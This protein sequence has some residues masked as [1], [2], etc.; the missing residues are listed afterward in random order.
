MRGHNTRLPIGH[1]MYAVGVMPLI[2]KLRPKEQPEVDVAF[3][4]DEEGAVDVSLNLSEPE[5]PCQAW[6]ADDSQA[7][8]RLKAIRAWWDILNTH[9]PPL[10]Y[11]PKP[12]KTFLVV[13]PHLLE[14]AK[15]MFE[16]TGIT[17][18]DGGKRDLGAAI[19]SAE[20][21]ADFLRE[22]VLKWSEQVECLSEFA[23]TQPHASHSAFVNAM[24]SKWTFAQ[25]TMKSL[26]EHMGPLE[27]AIRSK[28]IPALTGLKP[29]SSISDDMRDVYALPARWGGLG[30]D[31]PVVDSPF[32]YDESVQFTEQLKCL[33]R[34]GEKS[35]SLDVAE[36]K[37]IVELLKEQKELRYEQRFDDLSGRVSPE[38]SRALAFAQEKGASS[39]FSM[40]P[41]RE[42]G[43]CFGAKR[44][45]FD[46]IRLR[47]RLP[48]P[49]LPLTCACGKPFSLDHSQICKT[50]GFIH[51]RHDGPKNLWAKWCGDGFRDTEVEPLLEPLSGEV[52]V[53]KSAKIEEEARSDVRVRGFWG[54]YRNAFFEFR[55]FY[56]H[57]K[58]YKSIKPQA[59]YKEIARTRRR[60]YGERVLQCEDGDFTPMILS[61]SG[62]MGA[63]MSIAL[64]HVAKK[65]SEKH[66]L[67]YSRVVG[68]LR[69]MFSFEMMRLALICLRGSRSRFTTCVGN[70]V[71]DTAA[72]LSGLRM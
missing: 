60:E 54:N 18:T 16:G 72:I 2:D 41:V 48:I 57:A 3:D 33:V 30:I 23:R 55:V 62:G 13:K 32:K 31:N 25:R 67:A 70:D 52:F 53:Y 22:K 26:N 50:G 36:Q 8:G 63:E 27:H 28:L 66:N 7:V 40:V 68:Y 43:F 12:P 56:P 71:N 49:G 11:F 44:D 4:F 17:I 39:V 59:L 5:L 61:S 35:L 10:G 47:Y 38:L 1:Q 21:V 24:R 15:L 46:I 42:Y 65:V 20:F 45:W 64:K 34:D 6:Y 19:G 14:E 37:S 69:A 9:G 29:G 58:S 51:M